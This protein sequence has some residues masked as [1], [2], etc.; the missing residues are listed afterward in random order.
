MNLK[1]V[2]VMTRTLILKTVTKKIWL[3][4]LSANQRFYDF[5]A[6]SFQY[7]LKKNFEYLMVT[8]VPFEILSQYPN[9]YGSNWL[10]EDVQRHLENYLEKR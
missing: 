9:I 7:F 2:S 6:T 3:V 1:S 5:N 10:M 4:V 8:L